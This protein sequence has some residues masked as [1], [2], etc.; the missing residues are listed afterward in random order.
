MEKKFLLFVFLLL[1][2]WHCGS[3][4]VKPLNQVQFINL[5]KDEKRLWKRAAEEQSR[6][7][8]SGY[9]YEDSALTAY[10]NEVAQKLLP[11][12]LQGKGIDFR[13]KVLRNPLLNAFAYPNGIIYIHTGFL[14]KMENEAQLAALLGHEMTHVIFRHAIKNIRNIKSKTAL[15]SSLQI[16]GLPFGMYGSLV[17]L[18][19]GL[20]TMAAVSGYS[21][22]LEAAADEFGLKLM[23]DAG[24]DPF[25]ALK[26]FR[27]LKQEIDELEIKEPFFF[28]SHPRI[29]E[30]IASYNRLLSL[31][32]TNR[33]GKGKKFT[34]R[35]RK[36]TSK[37]ILENAQ[38]DLAMGRFRSTQRAIER[39]LQLYPEDA[40]AHYYLAESFRQRGEKK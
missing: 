10:L 33:K 29:T 14:A 9:L 20:G 40:R 15:Y 12:N 3:P 1:F 13:V 11:E 27:M 36:N 34:E 25:E 35:F 32:Y 28:G 16:L 39:Y 31:K 19:G 8:E 18:L 4:P 30:R 37:V 26:L 5:Q 22:D 24:Y 17:S 2:T 21:Q 38:L 7:D 23:T 6:L